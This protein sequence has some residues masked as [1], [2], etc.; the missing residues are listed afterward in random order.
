MFN[1]PEIHGK[2]PVGAT[3]FAIPVPAS[4]DASRVIGDAKLKPS[5]D[6]IPGSSALKLEEVAFTAYYPADVH[7]AKHAHKGVH[8]VPRPVSETLK[9]YAHFGSMNTWLINGLMAP[10]AHV[11]KIPLYV[12]VPLLDPQSREQDSEE[13]WPLVIFS[14]GLGGTRTTYSHFCARLAAEGRIVLA[15]E[16][17]DGTGPF[18]YTRTHVPGLKEELPANCKLYLHP[19][20]VTFDRPQTEKDQFAF[21]EDQLVFRRL[22]LYLTY[23]YISRLVNSSW[24]E[25]HPSL[26]WIHT[27]SGPWNH[28]LE[29]RPEDREF[30]RSWHIT[31]PKP[32]VQCD[33]DILLVGHSFGGATVLSTLSTPPPT[34]ADHQFTPLPVQRAVALDPWLEPLPGP[35]PEPYNVAASLTEH[36]TYA[37]HSPPALLV[38]N[39]E[40]FTV[41]HDHFA[42]L[43]AVVG[44]WD[45]AAHEQAPAQRKHEQFARL[46][47]LVRAQHITFSDFGVIVPFGAYARDGARF[48]DLTCTLADAF[49]AGSDF[50]EVLAAQ[51]KVE[52]EIEVLPAKKGGKEHKRLVGEVGNIIV[53]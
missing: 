47:T 33:H 40:Q 46:L 4:D 23:T 17:R 45:R 2:Y 53:H 10:Y 14:H 12:N 6:G 30:W 24:D 51:K 21:R 20:D 44:A 42:R 36:T 5:S 25:D 31:G 18:V 3:T 27:M 34:L 13:Q 22:E 15:I 41:W 37:T 52:F 48:L 19:E 32:K 16:H 43:R 1:L 9:G 50:D 29:N 49:L 35:G 39:S 7:S 11:L 38:L 26:D 8:W 28:D